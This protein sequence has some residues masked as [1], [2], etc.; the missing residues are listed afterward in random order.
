MT[1]R[2][3]KQ[4]LRF[5]MNMQQK[6]ESNAKGLNKIGV[7]FPQTLATSRS[8]LRRPSYLFAILTGFQKGG[9]KD[10][11]NHFWI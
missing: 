8:F 11:G 9:A 2:L 5:E 3:L 6:A 4:S 7:P 1:S 10:F